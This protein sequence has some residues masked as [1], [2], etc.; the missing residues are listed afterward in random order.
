MKYLAP[1]GAFNAIPFIRRTP[2]QLPKIFCQELDVLCSHQEMI[3]I[4]QYAPGIKLFCS[5]VQ[6][7]MKIMRERIH[8]PEGMPDVALVLIAGGSYMII[9]RLIMRKMG[10]GVPRKLQ[11]LAFGERPLPLFFRE[12]APMIISA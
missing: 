9:M 5:H 6:G 11:E 12:F 10:R 3:V 8:T 4:G 2:V 7:L 1:S